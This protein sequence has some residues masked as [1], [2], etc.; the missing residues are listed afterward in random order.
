M[1]TVKFGGIYQTKVAKKYQKRGIKLNAST[2]VEVIEALNQDSIFADDL[3]QLIK[4]T[5]TAFMLGRQLR[6]ARMITPEMAS[7]RWKLH[8]A[9]QDVTLHI[10]PAVAGAVE[11]TMA[12]IIKALV[13][14]AITLAVNLAM[15]ALFPPETPGAGNKRKSA[16]YENGLQTQKEGVPLAW[17]AGR[18]VWCGFNVIEADVDVT[19]LGGSGTS[20]TGPGGGTGGGG[21]DVSR[22]P[23]GDSFTGSYSDVLD[24]IRGAGGGGG[25]KSRDNNLFSNATLRILGSP[26]AGPLNVVG[27]TYEDQQKNIYFN[28]VPWRDP[29][30]SVLTKQG[31]SMAFRR[32]VPGQTA[33]PITPGIAATFNSSQELRKANPQGAILPGITNTVSSHDV[34]R[35]KARLGFTLLFTGKK[36]DQYDTDVTIAAKVKRLSAA[37]W[38]NA[39]SWT[40]RGKTTDVIQRQ[41]NIYAPPAS[42]TEEPWLFNIYRVTPDSDSDKLVNTSSFMGWTEIIDKELKYDGSDGGVPTALLAFQLD[43]SQFDASGPPE[44]ATLMEGREVDV[45]LG[46]NDDTQT[47]PEPW[48]GEWEKKATQNPVWHLRAMACDP[49]M[50]LGYD[51]SYF[52]KFDLLTM[53]KFCDQQTNGRRR[54]T[55]NEQFTDSE[56]G[57]ATL[58]SVAQSF[59]A[60]LYW[61]GGGLTLVQDRPTGTVDT[62][63]NNSDV[64]GRTFSYSFVPLQERVNEATVEYRDPDNFGKV[65]T[66]TYRD[67]AAITLC[68]GLGLPNGG[69]INRRVDKRGCN[70]RQEAY[71]YARKLVYDAQNEPLTVSWKCS[72]QGIRYLPGWIAEVDD[73][74][75]MAQHRGRIAE[76]IDANTIRLDYPITRVAYEAYTLRAN[77]DGELVKISLPV[78]E[79]NTTSTDIV[80]PAHGL[81]ANVAVGIARD[82][83]AQPETFR[84]ISIADAGKGFFNVTAK[85][86]DEGK[87]SYLENNVVAP[88]KVWPRMNF[89]LT[90][91]VVLPMSH[92]SAT[93]DILGVVH[94]LNIN[95]LPVEGQLRNYIVE[96][97][98]PEDAGFRVVYSGVDTTVKVP[99]VRTGTHH[100]TVTAV[101]T[102]GVSFDAG[103]AS[104]TL[105]YVGTS[106]LKAPTFLGLD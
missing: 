20:Y 69:R 92:S 33:I 98:S 34:H 61:N 47:Y 40:I 37:S 39:G 74:R 2:I 27:A 12:M 100:V 58:V 29:G 81:A 104:Y 23:F 4:D 88:I 22:N 93:D 59:G 5:P 26:G 84:I 18:R 48:L 101:N 72:L 49:D 3:K 90:K 86:H 99:N 63:I 15:S 44:I 94:T 32:G 82:D 87:F 30:S 9:G 38:T 50:G 1:I 106:T 102:L 103:T 11:I 78:V 42:G 53:A 54:Y 70:N 6:H 67:E 77:M 43:L 62:Y 46:Y 19:Q 68:Q 96:I 55:I 85:Q 52:N 105:N 25:G 8:K 73:E 28:E 66:V 51:E 17:V 65:A 60:M 91:P 31:V 35:V 45:P 76:I 36:G 16:L 95:W 14:V 80:V 79:A 56:D 89:N 21:G 83:E 75:R 57:W 13:T 10:V 41:L 7:G 24:L 97:W 71:D 64:E